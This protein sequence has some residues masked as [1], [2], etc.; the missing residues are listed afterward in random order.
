MNKLILTTMALV[1]LALSGCA[2]SPPAMTQVK[3]GAKEKPINSPE[4]I[5]A[6]Q[7]EAAK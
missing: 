2:V 6:M 4:F 1:A 5:K 7:D 3:E